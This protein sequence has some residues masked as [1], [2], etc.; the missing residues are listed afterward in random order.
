M[1]KIIVTLLVVG[2]GIAGFYFVSNSTNT[3]T[4]G[5]ITKNR[6]LESERFVVS[7]QSGTD[8]IIIDQVVMDK[9][10][11][12]VIRESIN[13]RPGQIIEV[14]DLLKEGIHTN[15]SINLGGVQE[16][17]GID[18]S[19]EFPLVIDFIAVVYTDDGDGGFNPL[20]DNVAYAEN[21]AL[22]KY[23]S[24]GEQAPESAVVPN[25]QSEA[26]GL[27]AA[28]V[29][30]TDE[31]FSPN[32]VEISNG[33]TVLFINKSS[34]PMWVASDLHPAHNVLPTFDQFGTSAFGESYS[35]TFDRF[36]EWRYHDHVNA[37][38]VG[39]II[40]N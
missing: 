7:A 12:V 11:F 34:R 39:V 5:G 8:E 19:G 10:G 16:I 38:E 35:Y 4:Q 27:A 30:Y 3:D 37:S 1:K 23:V 28:T 32:T 22:A 13:D 26:G 20:L 31:G 40:V 14:S 29:I 6:Y 21:A 17:N 9:P 25:M 33:D 18:I 36:G 24:T 2:I 15:V